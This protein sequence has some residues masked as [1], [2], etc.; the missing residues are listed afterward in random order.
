MLI[1]LVALIGACGAPDGDDVPAGRSDTRQIPTNTTPGLH[2]SGH[3]NVGVM[4]ES[5]AGRARTA[6]SP[7]LYQSGQVDLDIVSRF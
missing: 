4:S 5:G 1:A 6:S 2:L 7:R 3:V